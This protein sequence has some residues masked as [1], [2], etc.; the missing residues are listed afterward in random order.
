VKTGRLFGCLRA[1]HTYRLSGPLCFASLR[2]AIQDALEHNGLGTAEIDSGGAWYRHDVD[3]SIDMP[4]IELVAGNQSPDD[5]LAAHLSQELNRPFYRPR[6]R[7]FRLSAVDAG[8]GSHFISL[9]YDHWAADSVGARLLMRHVLG[10]YLGLSIPENEGTLE[11]YPGTSGEQIV[12][13]ARRDRFCKIARWT[14][15]EIRRRLLFPVGRRCVLGGSRRRLVFQ[16][17]EYATSPTW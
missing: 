2:K 11:L 9:I 12:K 6:C 1:A 7:P 14:R 17:L 4:E 10:R 3:D 13:C 16:S 15:C 8:P 5:R